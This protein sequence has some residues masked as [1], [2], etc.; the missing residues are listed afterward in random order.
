MSPCP[1][2]NLS[3][4]FPEHL[5]E[6]PP[7]A[8]STLTISGQV[9]ASGVNEDGDGLYDRLRLTVGAETDTAGEYMI[10]VNLNGPGGQYLSD[11]GIR[12]KLRGGE[13]QVPLELARESVG[14]TG[15]GVYE[16]LLTAYAVPDPDTGRSYRTDRGKPVRLEVSATEFEGQTPNIY[17][18]ERCWRMGNVTGVFEDVSWALEVEQYLGNA[19]YELEANHNAARAAQELDAFIERMERGADA[20]MDTPTALGFTEYARRL[21]AT[22]ASP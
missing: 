4:P 8:T 5:V 15:S 13:Q 11:Q 1:T 6:K 21:R 14:S 7:P 10:G 3:P 12:L 18:V 22:L 9:V 19:R 2:K 16:V 17:T 20:H